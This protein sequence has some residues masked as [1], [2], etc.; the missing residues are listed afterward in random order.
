MLLIQYT[1]KGEREL[2]LVHNTC[3]ATGSAMVKAEIELCSISVFTIALYS[4]SGR[5]AGI[6][7]KA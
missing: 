1:L 5:N 7:N 2:S 3:V 4:I 6:V